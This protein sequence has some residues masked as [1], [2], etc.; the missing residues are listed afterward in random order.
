[1]PVS[2]ALVLV[3]PALAVSPSDPASVLNSPRADGTAHDVRVRLGAEIGI[4]APVSHVITYGKD[5]TEF[6]YV[7]EGGQDVLFPFARF[8]VDLDA[9]KRHTF[10]LLYQPLDLRT[11]VTLE[12]DVRWDGV[13][14]PEGT[15]VELRYGFSFW[16]GSW[17][18]DL[19]PGPEREATIGGSLQIRNANLEITSTDGELRSVNRDVG[20]V[21]LIKSRFRWPLSN[22]GWFGAELD[23]AWAPIRYIN[24]SDSDVEGVLVDLSARAGTE[25]RP[26][27]DFFMNVRYFAGGA[28]G[29]SSN[30]TP[31]G[32]GF[33]ENWL[34]F[35]TL[36]AGFAVR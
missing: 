18:Y 24:G 11:S 1:M 23:A 30:A 26:G 10:V 36:S 28:V 17:M 27:V 15:P 16:R 21:P 5:G 25:L 29:T 34:H 9:G 20:P 2:A 33:S 6:D 4:V 35:L 32:D 22:E 7:E 8:G 31:P 14:F 13:D 12:R 19:L 3:L